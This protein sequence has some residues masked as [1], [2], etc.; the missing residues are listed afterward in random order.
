MKIK[1]TAEFPELRRLWNED[2]ANALLG[3]ENLEVTEISES[4]GQVWYSFEI[5]GQ[6]YKIP[7]WG[8]E[9]TEHGKIYV[10][11]QVE[12]FM[13]LAFNAGADETNNMSIDDIINRYGVTR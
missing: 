3:Q 5:D 2:Y 10:P 9:I 6:G 13:R 8:C 1:I 12:F 11:S 4:H 7:A